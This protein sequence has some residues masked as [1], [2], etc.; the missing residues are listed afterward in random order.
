MNNSDTTQKIS[1]IAYIAAFAIV[2]I[3]GCTFVQTKVL[4]N[5]GMYP[6]EIFFFRF[7]LA[8]I[9][10]MPLA[11]RKLFLDNFKDELLAI[12][13]GLSGGSLYFVTENYALAYGYC[14]NVSL[15][16]CLTPLITALI[17]GWLY[18]SE[19]LNKKGFIGSIVALSGMVLVVFNGNFILKLSPLGDALALAA[20]LC[21][22]IYSLIIKKLQ[23]RYSNMLITRKVFGYGLITI[24]PM[25][26]T[27][28]VNVGIILDGGIIVWGNIL[29]LGCIAS[30]LCFLGWNWCLKRIGIVRATNFIYLNPLITIITSALVLNE[31]VTWVAMLGA[32]LILGGLAYIDSNRQK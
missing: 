21:W 13:L 12:M 5:A 10:I 11:G 23:T 9:L 4:I 16:V 32:I 15:I 26:I 2:V 30:M 28:G 29:A 25:L 3:W 24:L 31:R 27:K 1:P 20:C 6:E 14:Y 22:A 19:R 7:A 17:V 8:Y 18:P